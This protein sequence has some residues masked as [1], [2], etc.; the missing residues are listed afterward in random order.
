VVKNPCISTFARGLFIADYERENP[1]RSA[2]P[3]TS[4]DANDGDS[5]SNHLQNYPTLESATLNATT[6]IQGR[7][8]SVPNT[9]FTIDFFANRSA[10]QSNY[11]EGEIPLGSISVT[12]DATGE[13]VFSAV[14]PPT[15]VGQWITATATDPKGNTS[16][17]SRTIQVQANRLDLTIE[18]SD[19]PS[20][21]GNYGGS[22]SI[23]VNRFLAKVLILN[24]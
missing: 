21:R 2:N 18:K 6:K 4:N 16:E 1:K 14:L 9:V 11:G 20:T 8:L 10:D 12:T 22:Q 24:L 17:F 13:A 5:G 19:V 23:F 7:L 15:L 3:P